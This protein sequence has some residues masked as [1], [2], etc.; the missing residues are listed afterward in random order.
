MFRP[1]RTGL[2]HLHKDYGGNQG[3]DLG[4]MLM[5]VILSAFSR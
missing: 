2:D 5:L 4:R 1:S 3:L